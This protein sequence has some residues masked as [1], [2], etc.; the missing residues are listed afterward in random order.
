MIKVWLKTTDDKEHGIDGVMERVTLS[1]DCEE[2]VCGVHAL[3]GPRKL[4]NVISLGE[5]SFGDDMQQ[6]QQKEIPIPRYMLK[7][8]TVLTGPK[9][10]IFKEWQIFILCWFGSP[11]YE[12]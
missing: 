9:V 1:V 6:L 4:I 3:D 12:S 11:S 7:M 2:Q 10:L 8:E 5:E